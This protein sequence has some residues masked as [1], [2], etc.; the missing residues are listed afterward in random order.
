MRVSN[1]DKHT[2]EGELPVRLCN[3]VDV[4]KNDRITQQI[5][6]MPATASPDEIER[7]RLHHN[8]VLI[9]KDSETWNDIGVPALVTEPSDDL[10]SGYH[11][12]ILR[13]KA[14]IYG[15][16]LFWAL[17]SKPAAYQFHVEAKGVTRY[18]LSHNGIQ[19]VTLPIPPPEEQ[20]AIVRFLDH[21][22]EQIQRYI[23]AKERLIALLEEERQALVHEAV[24]RGL[25]PNVRLKD[26]GV[27]WLGDVPEHWEV[28]RIRSITEMRVSNVDKHTKEEEIPVRLCNYT[29][30]YKN[31]VIDQALEFMPA[32]ASPEEVEKFR[33]EEQDVLITKDSETWDDIGIPAL[34]V[35]PSEDLICG[36]HLAILRPREEITGS[37]L[38]LALRTQGAKVQFNIQARGV[39]RYGLTH[40][41]ILSVQL[42]LPPHQEQQAIV[43]YLTEANEG[44]NETVARSQHQIDLMNEYRTRLIADVVTGQMDVR[45]AAE[46]LPEHI[47]KI[48]AAR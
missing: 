25:D 22:D 5:T 26:S 45:V 36:Y 12:A 30:V 3:Y 38:N 6:F 27:E 47:G 16:Y 28:R 33:L 44:I 40:N 29:D 4:Y 14:G 37:F 15:P 41:S 2:K 10:I 1:V 32:T 42:P 17:Q 24:T 13:P 20:A 39:T 46:E 9:T 34:V 7:F 43:D 23:A 21:A 18:G 11:L 19:S 31:E 35:E 48:G 8:D